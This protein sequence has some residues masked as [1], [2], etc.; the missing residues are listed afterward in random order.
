MKGPTDRDD[1]RLDGGD[2]TPGLDVSSPIHVPYE[3]ELPGFSGPLELLLHLIRKHKLDIID[4]PVGFI[5]QKYLEYIDAMKVLNLDVASEYLEM[6]ATLTRIKSRML[7]PVGAQ[8]AEEAEGKEPEDPRAELVRRLLEY[9]KYRDAADKLGA[10]SQLQRDVFTRPPEHA[11]PGGDRPLAEVGIGALLDAFAAVLKRVKPDLARE[12]T[13]ERISVAN[14]IQEL[15]AFLETRHRVRFEQFFEGIATKFDV[16]VTFLALLEMTKLHMARLLQA[17]PGTPLLV[18]FVG[19][20]DAA[21]DALTADERPVEPEPEK[22]P[23]IVPAPPVDEFGETLEVELRRLEIENPAS[24]STEEPPPAEE[25]E[26]TE[27]EEE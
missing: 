20:V 17:G 27:K 22:P 15:V 11:G 12:V 14:R 7:L 9:E 19:K 23:T 2:E 24:E 5:T 25:P 10:L 4:I 13:V 18:D 21:A 16:V 1:D 3:V 8:V 26:G 6:A